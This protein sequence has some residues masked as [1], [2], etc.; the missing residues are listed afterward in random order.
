MGTD[1]VIQEQK[2]K[3][4]SNPLKGND[5]PGGPCTFDIPVALDPNTPPHSAGRYSHTTTSLVNPKEVIK[6]QEYNQL[7][8][9]TTT[10]CKGPVEKK[11]SLLLK[12]RK[13]LKI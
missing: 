13:L 6:R 11:P 7:Y 1:R 3:E 8:S 10:S 12:V 4:N 2:E 5:R 9:S